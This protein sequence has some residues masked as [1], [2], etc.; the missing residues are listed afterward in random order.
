MINETIR[1]N[2]NVDADNIFPIFTLKEG[3]NAKIKVALFKNSVAFDVTGQTL[4]LGAK[5]SK[6]LIEQLDGFT[7]DKNNI[8]IQ[9]KNSILIPGVIEIDLEIKDAKGA[10]TTASFF[11]TV[12]QKVLNDTAV[13][14][15]NEFDTFTKTVDKIESDYTGLRRIII[16]ENQAAS[17]QDQ[18]NNVNSSMDN[19]KIIL[20]HINIFSK[21]YIFHYNTSYSL[22]LIFSSRLL[23]KVNSSSL[24]TT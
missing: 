6:G 10:M 9:L 11:I 13:E 8:D 7:V 12:N 1:K 2:I 5:T 24:R 16:D 14:A 21:S 17:L 4:R 23:I 20:I 22:D 19:I 3:D 18:I 15:T